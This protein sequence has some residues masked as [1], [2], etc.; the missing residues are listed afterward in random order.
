MSNEAVLRD[1]MDGVQ[2]NLR[3]A[4]T[5]PA[6]SDAELVALRRELAEMKA[7]VDLIRP[8]FKTGQTGGLIFHGTTT[9]G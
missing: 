7:F 4:V 6:S 3:G 1:V 5:V 8:H 9:C 2:I